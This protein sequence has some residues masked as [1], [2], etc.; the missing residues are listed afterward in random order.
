MPIV[1]IFDL[2]LYAKI[3]KVNLGIMI[4]KTIIVGIF[5][6]SFLNSCAQNS[7]FL[8]P[9]YTFG[10]TG[11]V[12]QAGLTYGSNEAITS[13]T[14]K[15][16]TENIKEILTPKEEDTEFERL[17]KKRIKQTRRKLNFASQ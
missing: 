5:L 6:I 14:G 7:A 17:V 8:G 2:E 11:N 9:I 15:S 4:I 12:Y 16:P 1:D 3:H 10:T 13:L